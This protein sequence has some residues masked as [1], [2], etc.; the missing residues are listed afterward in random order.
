LLL[1]SAEETSKHLLK[2]EVENSATQIDF[3]YANKPGDDVDTVV[4]RRIGQGPFR[5]LLE[6]EFGS[7]CCISGLTNKRLLIASHI[8]PW[9]KATQS[10]KTDSD[11]GLLLSVTWDALFDKGIISFSDDGALLCSEMLDKETIRCLGISIDER[12]GTNLLSEKRKKNLAWHRKW[13]G[14]D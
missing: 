4:K 8:I 2:I 9:S 6:H 11:N 14:F 1:S 5:D 3:E 12:L 13:F 7:A 10:E